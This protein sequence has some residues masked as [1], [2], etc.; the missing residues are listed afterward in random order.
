MNKILLLITIFLT[1]V[2]CAEPPRQWPTKPEPPRQEPTRPTRP[3]DNKQ[4]KRDVS[5]RAPPIQE[6]TRP[7]LPTKPTLP[8]RP[9]LPTKPKTSHKQ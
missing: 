4:N 3:I 8:T 5:S 6:P 9:T 2:I 1:S 7:T